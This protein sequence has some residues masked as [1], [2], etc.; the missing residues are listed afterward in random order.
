MK[1]RVGYLVVS[2]FCIVA[3][4]GI[5]LWAGSS[6]D[7]SNFQPPATP[8]VMEI[9]PPIAVTKIYI[10]HMADF[11]NYAVGDLFTE[12]MGTEPIGIIA[13]DPDPMYAGMKSLWKTS[14]S[15][16][17]KYGRWRDI[18][19]NNCTV[20]YGE[21]FRLANVSGSAYPYFTW[22]GMVADTETYPNIRMMVTSGRFYVVIREKSYS[23]PLATMDCGPVDTS[24]HR[25]YVAWSS[26]QVRIQF[27]GMYQEFAIPPVWTAFS[28][29]TSRFSFAPNVYLRHHKM[30]LYG[31]EVS[32]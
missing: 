10:Q 25:V 7:L 8:Q 21:T 4:L 16:Y 22:N 27:D 18:K 32:R 6:G 11:Q 9:V 3:A 31:P 5:M 13:P 30:T 28:V 26:S 2:I 24:Q 17:M 29:N 12:F 1:N 15:G 23:T 19:L 14:Q 20:E